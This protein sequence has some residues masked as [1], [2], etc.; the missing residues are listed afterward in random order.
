MKAFE[1][2]EK[3]YRSR[4]RERLW[5]GKL[6]GPDQPL[7][8]DRAGE[9]AKIPLGA[10]ERTESVLLAGAPLHK[11]AENRVPKSV[12]PAERPHERPKNPTA[13]LKRKHFGFDTSVFCKV[14]TLIAGRHH[15]YRLQY[16]IDSVP[17]AQIPQAIKNLVEVKQLLEGQAT[18]RVEHTRT[19]TDLQ[20]EGIRAADQPFGK[21]SEGTDGFSQRKNLSNT[22]EEE[23]LKCCILLK[24][25]AERGISGD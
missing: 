17:A 5:S 6:V 19:A 23:K 3:P 18:S 22:G 8:Q 24:H 7:A 13:A 21:E 12:L 14:R 15:V 25:H 2:R 16:H 20:P 9:T 4:G 10:Q 11:N 1:I